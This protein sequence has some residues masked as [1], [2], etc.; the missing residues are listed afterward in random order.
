MAT[1]RPTFYLRPFGPVRL[2]IVV[3]STHLE[4]K[5]GKI[6]PII[7]GSKQSMFWKYHFMKDWNLE[8]I[9]IIMQIYLFK[10]EIS[11]NFPFIHDKP[12]EG[13]MV[14]KVSGDENWSEV[15]KKKK[16]TEI[17]EENK[18]WYKNYI[19]R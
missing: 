3:F 4:G 5:I 17:F 13:C 16:A 6:N 14:V 1:D 11:K 2:T 8:Y 12:I 7:Y 18:Q 10:G 9:L 15:E 19:I